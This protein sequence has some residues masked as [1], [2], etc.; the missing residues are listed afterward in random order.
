MNIKKYFDILKKIMIFHNLA[1]EEIESLLSIAIHKTFPKN[2]TIV[3]Q[4]DNGDSMFIILKGE[5]KVSIFADNGREVILDLMEKGDFFGEMSL[6]DEMPRSANVVTTTSVETLMITRQE[7][8]T[9]LLKYP[10]IALNILKELVKR[11]RNADDVI[12]SLSIYDV[13]G[14]LAK[15]IKKVFEEANTPFQNNYEII[16]EFTHKDIAAR[17]GTARESVTRALNKLV[18]TNTISI[19]GRKLTLLDCE[20]LI[21]L[22]LK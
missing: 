9:Q 22:T 13:A 17:I 6:I 5:V 10:T 19:S 12:N 21:Q 4:H 18:E 1:D 16:F 14:R 20:N 11:L 3:K 15:F 7:F 8:Q 2:Y